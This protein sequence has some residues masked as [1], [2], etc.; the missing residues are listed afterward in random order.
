MVSGG[1]GADLEL[2]IPG[3]IPLDP[4]GM[5]EE[6]AAGLGELREPHPDL[7]LLRLQNLR[8]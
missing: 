4:G 1:H 7:S 2:F 8:L 3:W 5:R 6:A